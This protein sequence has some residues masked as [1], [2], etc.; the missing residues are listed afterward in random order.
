MLCRHDKIKHMNRP[1]L[2]LS[3]LL[4]ILDFERRLAILL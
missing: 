3:I 4:I 1:L 2:H